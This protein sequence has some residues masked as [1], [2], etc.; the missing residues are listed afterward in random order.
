[1]TPI[2]QWN[3]MTPRERRDWIA[4]EIMQWCKYAGH[5]SKTYPATHPLLMR[6]SDFNPD[7]DLNKAMEA[8][9]KIMQIN[10][11]IYGQNLLKVCGI[12]YIDNITIAEI[13]H[14]PAD[15]RCLAMYLTL[16]KER[17]EG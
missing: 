12:E 16:M 10:A 2:E 5:W 6:L 9:E 8:E 13:A 1:M 15:R 4:T 7:E 17:E 11:R 14:I 3:A